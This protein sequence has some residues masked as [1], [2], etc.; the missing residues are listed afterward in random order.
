MKKIRYC[1]LLFLVNVTILIA[2]GTW[3]PG[4]FEIHMINVGQGMCQ[5]VIAPNGKTLLMDCPEMSW[6]SSSTAELVASKIKKITGNT[7]LDYIVASHLHLD[8]IGYAGTGGIWALLNKYGLTCDHL[9]DRDAGY[10]DDINENNIYDD[11]EIVWTNAG[12]I[13]GT[14]EHW[15][16]WTTN[17]NSDIYNKREAAIYGSSEQIDLGDDVKVTIVQTNAEDIYMADSN[18]PLQGDH[19]ETKY[20]P[21]ENDY[22]TTLWIQFHEFDYVFGGDTDGEYSMS[23]WGYSYNDVESVVADL[24]NQPI[25]VISVNH[26]G[27][28]HSSNEKYV[29]TLHPAVALYNV[30][31]NSYGHPATPVVE[32][33]RS[34]G[35][36]QY[37]TEKGEL[38]LKGKDL[39]VVNGDI[40]IKTKDGINYT[41]N[42][43]KF[44]TFREHLKQ[45]KKLQKITNR[46]EEISL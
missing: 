3:T 27:S 26:H 40:V 24:I 18:T 43:K 42:G 8:H 44:E 29:A 25:E 6:N 14:S 10:W 36:L 15:I 32:R 7:H 34:I 17:P 21:S 2:S 1:I 20:A 9:I 45:D 35:A 31:N 28:S 4:T 11:G 33:F 41:V 19:T 30:G 38:E 23:S 5:L 46:N 39:K 12:T 16:A 13:S 22:S 37:F